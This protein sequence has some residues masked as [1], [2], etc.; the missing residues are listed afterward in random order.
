M[1]TSL[2]VCC[3]VV[4]LLVVGML[5]S[6]ASGN[7]QTIAANNTTLAPATQP[8]NITVSATTTSKP[9]ITS[10]TTSSS[11][12][13]NIT[14]TASTAGKTSLQTT[15]IKNVTSVS[16]SANTKSTTTSTSS[17]GTASSHIG[18]KFD[19]GSFIGG[20]LLTLGMTTLLFL[21]YKFSFA[22]REVQYRTLDEHDAII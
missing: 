22:R 14:S 4:Q 19:A 1:R 17:A 11:T 8:G 16:T 21:A 10:P 5:V 12:V 18:S 7:N 3:A 15:A 20:I 2:S 13:K 9:N 6:C